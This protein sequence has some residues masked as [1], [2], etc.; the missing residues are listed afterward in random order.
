MEIIFDAFIPDA[1]FWDEYADLWKNSQYQSSFQ[2]PLFRKSVV[3]MLKDP[4]IVLRGYRN[5][6]LVGATCF[7]KRGSE[8]LFLSDMKTD[9]NYFIL[10]KGL[11]G[12]ETKQYFKIFLEKIETRK[13]TFRL[14]KQPSWT[15]YMDIFR[16]ALSESKLYWKVLPYNPCLVLEAESPEALFKATNKQKLR[17]KLNR[18][19]EKDKVV[20]EVL[21]GEEDLDHWLEEFYETHLKRWADTSTASTY[22]D[23][24][25]RNFYKS[26]VLAW[27]KQGILVR[28]AIKL[29]SRRIA[30]VTALIE[31]GYLVHHSTSFDRDYE[32]Q[33]PGLII[34]NLI[35]RWMADRNMTKM[36]FGDGG[37]DYK[38]QF[39]K[40]ELPL[41]T[42]FITHTVNIP[43]ILNVK[44]IKF[45]R[46]HNRIRDFYNARIRP[47]L[48]RSKRLRKKIT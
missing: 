8:F 24:A 25:R 21:H 39:T 43:Y 40:Q 32:K 3:P 13:W 10:H 7:Y 11:T 9:H 2:A 26:C 30:F 42:I 41:L 27:I 31:N 44:L 4:P 36:E 47:V 33:S 15:S 28:F 23:P 19:K 12:A 38:Y 46:Q 35:G 45:I 17:Q 37:E 18:L 14:N 20:F 22:N 34:I 48:L 16:D 1:N 29:G 6:Q 5:E